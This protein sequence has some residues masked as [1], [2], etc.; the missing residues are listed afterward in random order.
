[1]INCILILHAPYIEALEVFEKKQ[2][3]HPKEWYRGAWLH[4]RF[5]LQGIGGRNQRHESQVHILVGFY[6]ILF[7]NYF[8]INIF[9]KSTLQ[10]DRANWVRLVSQ[11]ITAPGKKW[12]VSS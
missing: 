4:G 9:S 6:W 8:G 1:M 5:D 11:V 12:F 2:G 3:F 10:Y 7:E